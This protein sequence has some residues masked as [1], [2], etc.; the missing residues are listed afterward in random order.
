MYETNICGGHRMAPA[1]TTNGP[2][3]N[4]RNPFGSCAKFSQW[5]GLV[6]QKRANNARF[7][8]FYPSIIDDSH[9]QANTSK[10][11]SETAFSQIVF[12][13]ATTALT[14]RV[15]SRNRSLQSKQAMRHCHS[16]PKMIDVDDANEA[17]GG[18]NVESASYH[19]ARTS[20]E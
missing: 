18:L 13:P 20:R 14:L 16:L 5:C 9:N 6:F 1:G 8:R 12:C 17:N 11:L 10:P 4:P 15:S 7:C 3:T 19:C 2:I